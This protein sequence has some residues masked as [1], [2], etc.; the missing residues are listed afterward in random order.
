MEIITTKIAEAVGDLIENGIVI[1]G[2]CYIMGY[3]IKNT[4]CLKKI[5]NDMIPFIGMALGAAIAVIAPSI[6]IDDTMLVK[7]FKGIILGWAPT[8]LY[9]TIRKNK[10]GKLAE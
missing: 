1:F 8:G 3:S 7:I 4:K 6:F 10:K 9:E 5:P 2:L